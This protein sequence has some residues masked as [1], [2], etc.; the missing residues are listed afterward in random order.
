MARTLG[1]FTLVVLLAYLA[2]CGWLF[3]AQHS[4]IFFPQFTRTDATATDFALRRDDGTVLRGWTVRGDGTDPILYFGGNAQ[5]VELKQ[6]FFA[7]AAPG[8]AVYLVAYRGYGAS[9][10]APTVAL[11]KADAL[12]LFDEVRRL[13]PGQ[14]V[15]VVG[16]SLGSGIAAHVA[17]HRP[18]ARLALVTPFDSLAGVAQAHYPF[19]PVRLLLRTDLD[20]ATALRGRDG[21]PVLV[22][23]A[24]R[25]AVVPPASSERLLRAVPHAR[26]V[27]IDGV[28]HDSIVDSPRLKAELAR[29]LAAGSSA[30][31]AGP[32]ATGG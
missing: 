32:S 4:L 19:V 24:R 21:L 2:L 7:R 13:H 26:D 1:G 6:E 25:D 28:D 11:L 16:A 31:S 30:A 27:V 8:R 9:D 29:F 23:R 18:V 22:V 5:R 14:R 10:G 3:A 17:A 15:S 12:A 20:S